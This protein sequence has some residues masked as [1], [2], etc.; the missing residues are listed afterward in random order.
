VKLIIGLGNPGSQYHLSRHNIGYL[1][2]DN[3]ALENNIFLQKNKFCA[4]YGEGSVWGGKVI[5]A[6]PLT[7]M[8]KS[9]EAVN[10]LLNYYTIAPED[11][12]IIHDDMDIEYGRIKVKTQGGSA[13]HRGIMS[14]IQSLGANNFL[15]IRVGIGKP[16]GPA[17]PAVFVL[18][19]FSK[20]EQDQLPSLLKNVQCCIETVV[21]EGISAA[22]NKFHAAPRSDK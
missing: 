9:G 18:D 16:S 3:L 6:K 11:I 4:L 21:T 15:R 14:I 19:K 12:I 8:N 10:E 5:I 20:D 1:T 2:A 7:F 17:D 22:M 13:G